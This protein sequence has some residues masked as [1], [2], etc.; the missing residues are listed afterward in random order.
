MIEK[1]RMNYTYSIS[2][3]HKVHKLYCESV[4]SELKKG[5]LIVSESKKWLWL[6]ND[7]KITIRNGAV[8]DDLIMKICVG[9]TFYAAGFDIKVN[10]LINSSCDKTDNNSST[11]N[12]TD[13]TINHHNIIRNKENEKSIITDTIISTSMIMTENP[14]STSTKKNSKRKA[15]NEMERP[16]L[17]DIKN[18]DNTDTITKVTRNEDENYYLK[19]EVELDPLLKTKMRPHQIEGAKFILDILLGKKQINKE[20]DNDLTL[21]LSVI[22]GAILADEMG[23]GKT[24]TSLSVLWSLCRHG[25]CKGIIVCPKSLLGNWE[26]EINKWLPSSLARN[27][28]YV[29]GSGSAKNGPD[30]TVNRFITTHASVHPV[31]IINYE[32]FRSFS[33]ALNT[34]TSLEVLICDEG[35]RL[36]NA[37]G[38]KTSLA[39]GN[40]IAT[41][42]LV[43]TGTPIQ[44]NLEELFAVVQFTAPGFLGTLQEFKSKYVEVISNSRQSAASDI[45]R[46][47]GIIAASTLKRLLSYILLRRTQDAVLGSILPPR[48]DY[49]ILCN[50]QNEQKELYIN[51]SNTILNNLSNCEEETNKAKMN[52]VLSQLLKLRLICNNSSNKSSNE[53]TSS[54]LSVLEQMLLSVKLMGSEKVVVVS[55][56][57]TT[58]DQVFSIGRCHKWPMLRL[59]GSVQP[60][61]RMKIVQHFNHPTSEFFLMLLSAKAGGVGLN[62][63]GASRLILFEP[64]WNPAIDLQ[65]M[66]RIWRDGQTKPVFIYRLICNG[67]IEES[68]LNRQREKNEL[69]FVIKDS[70]DIDDSKNDNSKSDETD[71]I[72]QYLT[73]IHVKSLI[74]PSG[75]EG[76]NGSSIKDTEISDKLLISVKQSNAINI[77]HNII[78]TTTS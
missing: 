10:K 64:D 51:E 34:V 54:K 67:T 29:R 22:S 39:L 26:A 41:K 72:S 62:L 28:L 47:Q 17:K 56:F 14:I 8:D 76:L 65:A 46:K 44:N 37:Y 33:D 40:S 73:N 16:T 6:K 2:Y 32:M 11:G 3:S 55:N 70:S 50:L 4:V 74:I 24:L 30:A 43:L 53:S 38:N 58:L 36:K 68:I 45:Q 9:N 31:L 77:I 1:A 66:G 57:M 59:D 61:K 71:L 12:D 21:D 42:R 5:Y 75:F 27:A 49:T 23:C 35:H 7:Q 25:R 52:N 15:H 19:S 18:L 63:T 78:K 48:T 13:N 20:I 69:S 60:E